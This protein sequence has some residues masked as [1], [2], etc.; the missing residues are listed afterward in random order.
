MEMEKELEQFR[1]QAQRLKAGRKG[2]HYRSRRRCVPSRCVTQSTSWRPG[3]RWSSPPF[4]AVLGMPGSAAHL[5]SES[6]LRIARYTHTPLVPCT[7]RR[8]EARP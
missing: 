1:Q 5:A 6:V 3:G 7:R 2:A 8:R 4:S